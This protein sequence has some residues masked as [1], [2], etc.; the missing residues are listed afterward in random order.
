MRKDSPLQPPSYLAETPNQAMR[1]KLRYYIQ[2]LAIGFLMLGMILLLRLMLAQQANPPTGSGQG[3][4]Q[5][6]NS[7]ATSPAR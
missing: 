1:R 2:G 5:S 4:A 3:G 6:P 7:D